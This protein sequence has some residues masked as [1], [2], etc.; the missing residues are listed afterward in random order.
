MAPIVVP[1][2]DRSTPIA[3][4]RNTYAKRQREH[5]KQQRAAEKRAKRETKGEDDPNA[6]PPAPPDFWALPDVSEE[7]V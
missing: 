1:L 7:R 2:L 4:D 6:A 3:K 5:E